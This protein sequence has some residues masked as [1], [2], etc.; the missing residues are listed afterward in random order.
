LY[1]VHFALTAHVLQ[2][3]LKDPVQGDEQRTTNGDKAR[4][5]PNDAD[6]GNGSAAALQTMVV[7]PPQPSTASAAAI[8]PPAPLAALENRRSSSSL[9]I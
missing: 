4:G 3:T 5:G 8:K 1:F 6:A 2:T 9:P 7:R